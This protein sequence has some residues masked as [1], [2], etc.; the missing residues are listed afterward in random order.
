MIFGPC[1][2]VYFAVGCIGPRPKPM[3]SRR[4]KRCSETRSDRS[5]IFANETSAGRANIVCQDDVGPP[6]MVLDRPGMRRRWTGEVFAIYLDGLVGA[7]E[8]N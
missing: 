6:S 2:E 7:T 8:N 4:A 3:S 5:Q 1:S